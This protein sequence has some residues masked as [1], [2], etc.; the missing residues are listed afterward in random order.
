MF[1]KVSLMPYMEWN[2]EICLG[3]ASIDD[4]HRILLGYLNTLYDAVRINEGPKVIQEILDGLVTYTVTHFLHEEE[5]MFVTQY[6][7]LAQHKEQHDELRRQL[8]SFQAEAT[9]HP[10]QEICHHILAFLKSWF[11]VHLLSHDRIFVAHLKAH[12]I[13]K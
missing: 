10:S 1:S 6:S 8:M 7:G 13:T 9:P 12:G 4:E 5:Y 3:I 11:C 2:E